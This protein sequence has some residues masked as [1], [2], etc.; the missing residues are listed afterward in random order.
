M[1]VS[2]LK[3]IFEFLYLIFLLIGPCTCFKNDQLS[4]T[5]SKNIISREFLKYDW[6]IF[7]QAAQEMIFLKKKY[8][9]S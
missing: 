7:I 9:F 3:K 4:I 5:V 1:F 6:S 8:F 2:S